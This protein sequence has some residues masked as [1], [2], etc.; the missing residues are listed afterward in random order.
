MKKIIIFIL[1]IVIAIGF[2]FF[3]KAK[4]KNNLDIKIVKVKYGNLVETVSNSGTLRSNKE[5]KLTT[6]IPGK[7]NEIMVSENQKVNKGMILL[8]LDTFDQA[9]KDYNRMKYLGEKEFVSLQ[10]IELAKKQYENTF[11]TAPFSGTIV[12]KFFEQEE[13]ANGPVFL[14][15]DLDDMIIETNID[16][17]EIG[18][19]KIEQSA[20]VIIDAY[21]DIENSGKVQFIAKTSLENKEKGI[22]YQV[23]I[24][25]DPTN[26]ILRLGMTADVNI[27]V[28]DK[29]NVLIIPYTAISEEKEKFFVFVVENNKLKKRFIKTGIENYEYT[30]IISGLKE[31]E[32][33]V[34]NNTLKLQEEQKLKSKK[35]LVKKFFKKNKVLQTIKK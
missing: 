5:V 26:I 21:K 6:T 7:I 9:E 12:K 27:K 8:K 22:T 29:K 4:K 28:M 1:I 17:T 32:V 18:K 33:I 25:L 10:Q 16:E 13:M 3:I 15:A 2:F 20:E 31:N 19:V 11:I 30:E 14:I 23:K 34:E 35:L 24:R